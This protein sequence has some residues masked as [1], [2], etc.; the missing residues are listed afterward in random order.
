MWRLALF[1]G[2]FYLATLRAGHGWGD[3]F[4]QYIQHADNIVAGVPY[5]QT[6]YVY[7][8]HNPAVGPRAYPPGFPVLLAPVV[9]LFGLDFRPMKVLI[10]LCF[11]GVLLLVPHVFR[12][13]LTPPYVAALVLLLGLNPFMW[14]F[15]D[16]VLS[17]VPFLLFILLAIYGFQCERAALAGLAT[18]AA[19]ATRVLGIVLLPCFVAHDLIQRRRVSRATVVACGIAL[20]LAAGQYVLGGQ[21]GSY[22]DTLVVSAGTLGRNI[23]D[24]LGALSDIWDDGYTSIARKAVFLLT[25]GFT[26]YGYG[27]A[28][29][30][31]PSVLEIFPVLYLMPIV[32]WPAYQGTRFLIPLLPFYLYYCLRGVSALAQ[33]FGARSRAPRLAC[34]AIIALVYSA[35]YSTLRFGPMT[36]GVGTAKSAA[37]FE[38]VKTSTAAGDVFIFSKPRALA[39]FTGRRAAAPSLEAERCELWRFMQQIGATYVV[40]GPTSVRDDAT[41]GYL[42]E[43]VERFPRSLQQ[44]MGNDEVAVYRI[45]GDPCRGSGLGLVA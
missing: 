29:R 9:K 8:P 2:V 33:R 31:G 34:V 10:V 16:Q 7:N 44:V 42:A 23:V 1:V 3:D 21:E 15:K 26:A 27:R 20:A 30:S 5:A 4:A 40:T 43:F 24:Y 12:R 45:V 38:F 17:D 18:Y 32:L 28:V 36:E 41:V 11:V 37:L 39:L 14:Q 19:I 35:K 22:L 25:L 13:D 6:G